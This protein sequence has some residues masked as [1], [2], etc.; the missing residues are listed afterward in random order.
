MDNRPQIPHDEE[1]EKALVGSVLINPDVYNTLDIT[2]EDFYKHNNANIWRTFVR[3]QTSGTVID[4]LTVTE[5]LQR[6]D[7]LNEIGGLAYLSSLITSVPSSLHVDDYA[8]IVK[9]YSRRRQWLKIAGSMAASAY[10]TSAPIDKV[11]PQVMDLFTGSL[12][13]TGSAA[14]LRGFLQTTLDETMERNKNPKDIWGIRTGYADLD[15]ATGGLQKGEVLY[16]SGQPGVGKSIIAMQAGLQ[17]A[18]NGHPG[19]IYSLEMPGT[20]VIRR[21]LAYLT[22]IPTRNIKSG[23]IKD[24]EFSN[25]AQA[26]GDMDTLPLYMSDSPDWTTISL[27]ADL[28][29][30]KAAH[31]IEWFVLDYAYLL[32][33]MPGA[34]ENERS[35]YVSAQIKSIC[36][37]L[38]L[39]G[40]VVHS[41]R[42]SMG[43]PELMDL[44][45]SGQQAY[46]S[47]LVIMVTKDDTQKDLLHCFFRK[48]RELENPDIGFDLLKLP[49]VPA[50]GNTMRVDV[51]QLSRE[52]DT[53]YQ[54]GM[55]WTD[56]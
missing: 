52:K 19:A 12:Q 2:A 37:A 1:T 25:L 34:S 36:R 50:V 22:K 32:K 51:N 44:R 45:G 41:L 26:I 7:R 33:D 3:L 38:G 54:H 4:L 5:D 10:D 30:L 6:R 31:G 20:Q 28:S 14:P 56:H 47:D 11:A 16:L 17:M 42:K 40:V 15:N 27:R 35:G 18:K 21:W 43:D 13:V 8:R 46:D 53:P 39:A 48:G 9:D 55:D 29:R 23:R 24:V 49:G